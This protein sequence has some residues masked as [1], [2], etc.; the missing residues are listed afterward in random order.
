MVQ[1]APIGRGPMKNLGKALDA[2]VENIR[3]GKT[4]DNRFVEP[5]FPKVLYNMIAHMSW[6]IQAKRFGLKIGRLYDKPL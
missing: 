2:L 5:N 6:R 4:A 3:G 1:A